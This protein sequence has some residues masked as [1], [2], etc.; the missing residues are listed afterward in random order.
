MDTTVISDSC[1]INISNVF[2]GTDQ[3]ICISDEDSVSLTLQFMDEIPFIFDGGEIIIF[4]GGDKSTTIEK[5]QAAN[6][7]FFTRSSVNN[8]TVCYENKKFGIPFS[9]KLDCEFTYKKPERTIKSKLS[10]DRHIGKLMD[11]KE[12]VDKILRDII[13]DKFFKKLNL[14]SKHFKDEPFFNKKR[15]CSYR[16]RNKKN[17]SDML[18]HI[19]ENQDGIGLGIFNRINKKDNAEVSIYYFAICAINQLKFYSEYLDKTVQI[20]EKDKNFTEGVTYNDILNNFVQDKKP[21]SSS[22]SKTV[23]IFAPS[24]PAFQIR[25]K[26]TGQYLARYIQLSKA[27]NGEWN[28]FFESDNKLKFSDE[29]VK[30]YGLSNEKHNYI[31]EQNNS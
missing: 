21:P 18:T 14:K 23:I 3:D 30:E 17:I 10:L 6:L 11:E 2:F 12:R 20:I 31:H 27:Y 24:C 19:K 1:H 26:Q 5:L 15:D 28:V 8:D 7:Y 16:L 25:K 13:E 29:Q 22:F 9:I 4:P